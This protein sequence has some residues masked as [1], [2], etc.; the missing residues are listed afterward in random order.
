MKRVT[1]NRFYQD[2]TCTL[3]VL[4]VQ[5]LKNPIFYT[6]ERPWLNNEKNTSCIP[7]GT[8]SCFIRQ[9][10]SNG[11]VYELRGV[12]GR[13]FI[14]IHKG[15]FARNVIGCIAI[16]E[17]AGYI[18]EEKA[19]TAS[20]SAMNRFK[21]IMEYEDFVLDIIGGDTDWR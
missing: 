1:L 13:D 12:E 15:N 9:S 10:P 18:G 8:Y 21:E 20:T 2:D 3:G 16:G 6:I 19:V 11:E 4:S 5:G 7:S 14:Q 17:A